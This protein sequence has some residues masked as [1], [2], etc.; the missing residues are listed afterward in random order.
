MRHWARQTLVALLVLLMA[1][2]LATTAS[3]KNCE[4]KNTLS[5]WKH[6]GGMFRRMPNPEVKGTF[7]WK[8]FDNNWNVQ[9]TFHETSKEWQQQQV[10][11]EDKSRGVSILLRAD[12]CGIKQSGDQQFQKLYSGGWVRVID[13]V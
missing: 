5:A 9:A 8:E 10:I 11:L 12:V 7:V 2:A 1:V 4:A 3:A 13:C 6:G